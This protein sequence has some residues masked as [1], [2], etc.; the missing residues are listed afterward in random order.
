MTRHSAVFEILSPLVGLRGGE[1]LTAF[2]ISSGNR[3]LYS[4]R[5]VVRNQIQSG[6]SL[7]CEV[8]LSDES[9]NDFEAGLF[10]GS[11]KA[12]DGQY[13]A[14]LKEWQSH[15][16]I[17]PE[18]KLTVADMQAFLSDLSMWL[19]QVEHGIALLPESMRPVR[20]K[21]LCQQLADTI[22]PSINDIFD[23][24]EDVAIRL[25]SNHLS[26]H[27]SYMRRH[28]HSL[29]LLAPFAHR[30]YTK[31]LG[32]AGDYEMINMILRDRPEGE[33]LFGKILHAWFVRQQPAKAHRN[34]IDYLISKIT[35]IAL[36]AKAAGRRAEIFNMACGPASEVQRFISESELRGSTEFTLLDFNEETLAYTRQCIRAVS[37][38]KVAAPQ[39]KFIQK[40]V[41]HLLK[42]GARRSKAPNTTGYDLVYCAGLFD[43][44]TDEVC[45]RLMEI[46]YD[47]VVPGGLLVATNVEPNNP[48]RHGMDHL[49]DWPLNYRTAKDMMSVKPK[50]AT[51][52]DVRAYSDDTGVNVFLEV[53]KP[54]HG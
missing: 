48:R 13:Q 21:E 15:L 34:R 23:R 28:L 33:S 11:S 39:V 10:Q 17:Q 54:S 35:E 50:A 20:E 6:A 3:L 51:L 37:A 46:M 2:T 36:R 19:A 44:L 16:H 40:S 52:D 53:F 22:I 38:G 45:R 47:W 26:A 7:I 27:A 43:Y 32:Y 25:D 1:A 14:F 41:H 4:G 24:F 29:A 9:W 42:D 31:P 12:W 30:T 5:A 18:Y 49:L 8:S